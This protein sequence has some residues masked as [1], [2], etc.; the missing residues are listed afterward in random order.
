MSPKNHPNQQTDLGSIS[1]AIIDCD[2]CPRLRAHCR[3]VAEEKRKAFQSEE[4]WGGPVPGFGDIKSRFVIVGLAPAAHGANRTG[5]IFT[6][7]R[8]GEWLYR[9]LHKQGFANQPESHHRDD[10]LELRDTWVT[11]AVHCAPPDNKPLPEEFSACAPHL[12]AELN[13]L[14]ETS[15]VFLALGGLALKSLWP[16]L[17]P[18][19][20]KAPKFQHGS[21]IR[22]PDGRTL[23]LSYHPS[24]QN[25]FTGRLTEPMFDAVFQRARALLED[26]P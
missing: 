20:K 17:V 2:R 10:G 21:E 4:Y 16:H 22:L 19:T 7:D 15:R 24:Q 5:R 23:L 25:T 1:Q 14:S 6:G 8:S 11:C 3:R 18:A 12:A 26:G 9:A 13:A